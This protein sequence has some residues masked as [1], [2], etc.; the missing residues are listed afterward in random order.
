M[1]PRPSSCAKCLPP[2]CLKELP[3]LRAA[4]LHQRALRRSGNAWIAKRHLFALLRRAR[5][6]SAAEES[7]YE[8]LVNA[9]CGEREERARGCNKRRVR[10]EVGKNSTR[11]RAREREREREARLHAATS[12]T[13]THLP[14]RSHRGKVATERILSPT[15]PQQTRRA[16]GCQLAESS[17]APAQ[18]VAPLRA[19]DRYGWRRQ[20]QRGRQPSPRAP[21]AA[22]RHYQRHDAHVAVKPRVVGPS[23][24][25]LPPLAFS[26]LRMLQRCRCSRRRQE[27]SSRSLHHPR[28]LPTHA[29]SP[30]Q[31][32]LSPRPSQ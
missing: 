22:S 26:I 21:K 11:K 6:K 28:R 15:C 3:R 14:A 16:L 8:A 30:P 23:L 18:S 7:A 1:V 31:R 20:S 12:T 24:A 29:A 10:S 5:L 9:R 27:S 4:E 2:T 17:S 32:E 13:T 19:R 25:A